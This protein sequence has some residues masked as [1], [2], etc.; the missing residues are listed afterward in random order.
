MCFTVTANKP[1]IQRAA[2]LSSTAVTPALLSRFTELFPLPAR[3]ATGALWAQLSELHVIRQ[4]CAAVT[5]AMTHAP[6]PLSL[7]VCYAAVN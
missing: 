3:L 4:F 6:V 7:F 5:V 2:G 1:T